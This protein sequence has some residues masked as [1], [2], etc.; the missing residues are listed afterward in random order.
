MLVW[1]F[2]DISSQGDIVSA[3]V[4]KNQFSLDRMN[5]INVVGID[6]LSGSDYHL[7]KISADILRYFLIQQRKQINKE[8]S[9]SDQRSRLSLRSLNHDLALIQM[10]S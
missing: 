8:N 1:Q 2:S 3:N 9:G 6:S 4:Y 7:D 10:R 5:A